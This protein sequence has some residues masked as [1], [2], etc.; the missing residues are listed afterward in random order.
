MLLCVCVDVARQQGDSVISAYFVQGKSA[1]VDGSPSFTATT[2]AQG[3]FQFDLDG[4][5][6]TVCKVVPTFQEMG[7]QQIL[8]MVENLNFKIAVLFVEDPHLQNV[9]ECWITQAEILEEI[10]VATIRD[11]GPQISYDHH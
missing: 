5:I 2:Y 4:L 11:F 10:G 6:S 1:V 7:H 3:P 8:E 9:F